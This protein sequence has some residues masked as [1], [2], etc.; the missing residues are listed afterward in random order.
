MS[1]GLSPKVN[2]SPELKI[3]AAAA[4]ELRRR[5]GTQQAAAVDWTP[6]P[7]PQTLAMESRAHFIGYGGAAGGG[8]TDLALGLAALKH[9]RSVIFRRVFPSVR[10]IIERSREIF[11]RGVDR[12]ARDSYNEQLHLWRLADGR[13]IEFGSLQYDADKK[14]QQGQARDFMAFDEATEFPE[15]IVR[16]VSAWCRTTRDDVIPQVLLTFNPPTDEDG[17]WVVSFF[18][19][20][21]DPEYPGVRAQPGELRWFTTDGGRDVEVPEGTPGAKSRTFIPASLSDNP[22]L[23]ATGYG[24]TIAALPEP[25]RSILMGDFAAGRQEDPWK[26]IPAPWV[27]AA[28]ARPRP[29]APGPLTALGVDVARGGADQTTIARLRGA[30]FEPLSAY[31]GSSTPSGPGVGALVLQQHAEGAIVG[32]DVVGVGASV[33]DHLAGSVPSQAI[34]AGAGCDATDKSGR[35]RFANVR[36]AMWWA[37]REALDPETGDGVI[38]PDDPELRADLCAPRFSVRA[39]RILVESKDEVRKRIGRSTDRADAVLMAW[40]AAR[41]YAPLLLWGDDADD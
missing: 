28:Q 2:Y 24:D 23:A 22:H 5:R 1:Y 33:Y 8:K 36:A 35:L 26:V 40:W 9:R 7:G 6:L 18:A 11:A 30:V 3:R 29:A 10:G 25:L 21:L 14:K 15:S 16:F 4:L 27:R 20:W 19:P 34:S 31:P 38:L 13:M 41:S 12:H 39:G 37:F 17:Q 32:I